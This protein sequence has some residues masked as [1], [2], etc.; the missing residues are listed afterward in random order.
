MKTLPDTFAALA[1]PVRLAIV[2]RLLADGPQN[3]GALGA[4]AAI[5]AP[6]ISR[7]LKV[8]R[9]AGIVEREVAAQHRIYAVRPQA[10]QG[11]DNWVSDRR[12]FW[13]ASLDRL[14]AALTERA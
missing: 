14:E 3:A 12:K 11:I 9:E 8:L 13:Q 6:A 4:V 2:E 7:H 1:D 10:M 5:S